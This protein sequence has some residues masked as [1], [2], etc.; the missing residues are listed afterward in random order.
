M[1][2]RKQTELIVYR[3]KLMNTQLHL[4]VLVLL[5]VACQLQ[6]LVCCISSTK[7]TTKDSKEWRR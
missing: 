1:Q 4:A 2:Y 5:A 3:L 7:E 6:W